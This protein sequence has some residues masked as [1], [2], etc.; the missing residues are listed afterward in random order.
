MTNTG[1]HAEKNRNIKFFTDFKGR[2]DIILAFLAVGSLDHGQFGMRSIQAVVLLILGTMAGRIVRGHDNQT[3]L[4]TGHAQ[5]KHGIGG[6]VDADM[7][8]NRQCAHTADRRAGGYFQR[9]L[10][11][12][13][14]A[15]VDIVRIIV[16]YVFKNFRAGSTGICCGQMAG[17]FVRT[18]RNGLIAGHDFDLHSL[19]PPFLYQSFYLFI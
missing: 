8:H 12:G 11:I 17:C 2:L 1:G 6:D 4:H 5:S 7:F 15:A 13:G 18:S 3:A 9:G 10:F 19:N 16:G 14:P